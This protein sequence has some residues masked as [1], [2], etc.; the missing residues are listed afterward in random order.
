MNAIQNSVSMNPAWS[1]DLPLT[2]TAESPRQLNLRVQDGVDFAERSALDHLLNAKGKGNAGGTI[3]CP[4]GTTPVIRPTDDP[5]TIQIECVPRKKKG[6]PEPRPT[7]P[8][9]GPILP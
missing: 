6:D 8:S 2:K 4:P 9:P 3:T 7:S 5:Q 1:V